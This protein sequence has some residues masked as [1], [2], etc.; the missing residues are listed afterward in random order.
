M[1]IQFDR[2]KEVVAHLRAE[3][4][5]P[6]DRGQTHSSLKAAC[7]EE[8]AELIC[9]INIL[10]ETQNADNLK[11]ELGDLLFLILLQ[12]QIASEEGLFSIE[13]VME[14]ISNKM[15]HRHPHVFGEVTVSE[16]GKV[17]DSWESVKADEK[18][19]KK[20]KEEKYLGPAIEE[21]KDLLEVAK[22]RKNL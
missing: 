8:A 11:E 2:L 1:S 17:L 18:A 9:G 6:W 10:E 12:S 21:S 14:G 15:I 4:G 16:K 20:I 13:D 19:R 3:D 5:C 7:I 22:Q